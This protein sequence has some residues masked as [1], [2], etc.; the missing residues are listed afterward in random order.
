MVEGTAARV[1]LR[2]A[3][4]LGAGRLSLRLPD[5]K[6]TPRFDRGQVGFDLIVPLVEQRF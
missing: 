3:L 6:V 5:V 1:R 4:D 2:L